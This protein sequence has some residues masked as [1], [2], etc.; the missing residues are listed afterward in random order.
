[1]ALEAISLKID[2]PTGELVPGRGFYQLEEDSLY[3]QVGEYRDNRGFFNYLESDTV[4]FDIDKSG[5]LLLIEVTLPRRRWEIE[6]Q[7]TVPTIAET[8]D[9]RWLDFRT[10]IPEPRLVTNP[11]QTALLIQFAPDGS[12][13]WFKLAEAVLVQADRNHRLTAVMVTDIEDDLAGRQ[14][15]AFRHQT[16]RQ[17]RPRTKQ[18]DSRRSISG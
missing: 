2:T 3:V 8:A 14:I 6:P 15:A 4:R 7:M 16:R 12:W 1:M 13:R 17:D 5:R 18:S 11:K 10:R 9:I